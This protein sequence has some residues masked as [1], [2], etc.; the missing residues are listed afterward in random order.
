M[1]KFLLKYKNKKAKKY[2]FYLAQT[3]VIHAASVS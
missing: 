1:L 2:N 3:G